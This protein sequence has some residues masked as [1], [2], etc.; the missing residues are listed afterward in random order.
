MLPWGGTDDLARLEI[1]QIVIRNRGD[2]EDHSSSKERVGHEGLR[3]RI[4]LIARDSLDQQCGRKH[5][6]DAHAGDRGIGCADEAGHVTTNRGHD[7]ANQQNVQNGKKH[8]AARV[9]HDRRILDEEPQQQAH[10]DHGGHSD[11]YN[12][13]ERNVPLG[14]VHLLAIVT[15]TRRSEG[16]LD[17]LRDR[18]DDLHESPHRGNGHRASTDEANI[19]G[20]SAIHDVRECFTG[21]H[22]ARRLPRKKNAEG[23]DETHDHGN[24]DRHADQV[25]HANEGQG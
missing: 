6:D 20:E 13:R 24:T 14:D 2:A 17:A 4:G 23:D 18:A 5:N 21:I 22:G 15:S 7:E 10:R 3:V 16:I 25:T 8:Q 11:T 9:V 12:D 1:L 19:C